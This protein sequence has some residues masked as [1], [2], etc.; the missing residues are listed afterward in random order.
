[1]LPVHCASGLICPLTVR[2]FTS[3]HAR[4]SCPAEPSR[5]RKFCEIWSID[6]TCGAWQL[7]HSTLLPIRFTCFSGSAV[8]WLELN[9]DTRS[10]ESTIGSLRLKGCEPCRLPLNTSAAFIPPVIVIVP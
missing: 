10:G 3:W 7:V 1:M 6:C 4:Q 5:T 2:G 9:D 8:V